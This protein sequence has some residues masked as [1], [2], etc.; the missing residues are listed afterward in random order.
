MS[1]ETATHG[2][3]AAELHE[4]SVT[5]YIAAPPAAVWAVMTMRM[6]EWWAPRPWTTEVITLDWKA[7]APFA[8]AMC[9]PDGERQPVEGMLLEVREGEHYIFTDA[10]GADWVPR[11]PFMTGRF[12][13]KAE[14]AGTRYTA[15][16]RHW[17]AE[18]MA[19]HDAMGFTEG[20]GQV[21]DQLAEI[22]ERE[23]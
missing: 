7:G 15:S 12:A 23:A 17:D 18:T 5:R 1:E 9:G 14:G 11:K 16:A 6:P 4:L 13:I 22:C 19:Q 8:M 2:Q 20:W 10:F 3:T 21:A